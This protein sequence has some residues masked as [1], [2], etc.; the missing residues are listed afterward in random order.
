MKTFSTTNLYNSSLCTIYILNIS[1]YDK[2]ITHGKSFFAECP[3][4]MLGKELFADKIFAE[5]SLSSVTLGKG[6]AECKM[7]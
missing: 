5:Y 1:S 6:F 4:K 2:N 3:K 7:T